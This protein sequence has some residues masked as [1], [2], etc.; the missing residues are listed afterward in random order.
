[1]TRLELSIAWR[2]L[3]SRSASRLLNFISVIAI[4]GVLV[5][6]SALIV[7]IG[8]MNGLQHDLREKILVG[9]PDI[10]VLTYGDDLTMPDWKD[11]LERV[12]RHEGIVAAAPFVLTQA[13]VSAGHEYGEG[14]M[15]V[16]IE[17]PGRGVQE[18]T[19]IRQHVLNG[20]GDFSF[21]ATDGSLTG[22]VL[23]HR[24]AERL[25]VFPGDTVTM[26][27]FTGLR[28]NAAVGGYVPKLA[29]YE[30]TGLFRTGMYE[31]DNS[32]IYTSI[33]AAQG[34]AGLSEAVT[35]IEA[36]T[37]DRWRASEIGTALRR[38]LANYRVVDWQEQNASLFQALK[39]EKFGMGIILLLIV[40]VAAFNIVSTLTMV[41]RD[42]TR[43]IGILKAMGL[44]AR[45]IRRIFTAQGAV[46]GVVG[47]L[48]G[49]VVGV[50]AAL[51]VERYELI[52][53]NPSVYFIDHLPVQLAVL[54]V[55]W[56]V[57][58]SIT[59]A[60]VATV[61]PARQAARLYPVDAIRA[62]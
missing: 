44:P 50:G 48:I 17:P 22:V 29:K 25:N 24:L 5:G 28:Y 32:Y 34:L 54:D 18:P 30:V 21:K 61:Y 13:G 39:L 45:S 8:V 38:S 20:A 4:G 19:S 1:M 15:V 53:L 35:G 56:I 7:I 12:R 40:I 31:Y 11:V 57:V 43:E 60:V 9:S 10:R 62:E 37:V 2:Y 47:T 6:V 41:V 33:E 49:L 58:A 26:V 14:A 16:G 52:K 23:G 59:I 3:R 42:K 55:L 51:L 36:K 27:A 46:I